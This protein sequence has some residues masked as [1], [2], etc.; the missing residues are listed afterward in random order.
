MGQ[1]YMKGNIL[2][3]LVSHDTLTTY[4]MSFALRFRTRAI[5]IYFYSIRTIFNAY[6]FTHHISTGNIR[7]H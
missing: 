5:L 4:T 1:F 6:I 7:L 3:F 2:S